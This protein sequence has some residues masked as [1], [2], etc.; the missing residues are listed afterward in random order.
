MY[1]VVIFLYFFVI[2]LD[3]K[4][5]YKKNSKKLN[6]LYILLSI[7]GFGLLILYSLNIYLTDLMG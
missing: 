6:V 3:F 5:H 4:P 2:M 1:I 7:I